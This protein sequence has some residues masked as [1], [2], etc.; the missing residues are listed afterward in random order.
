M[1]AVV[2]SDVPETQRENR[3]HTYRVLF[4]GFSVLRPEEPSV[5]PCTQ[6]IHDVDELPGALSGCCVGAGVFGPR[7]LVPEHVPVLVEDRLQ[8]AL[9]AVAEHKAPAGSLVAGDR[10]SGGELAKERDD[11]GPVEEVPEGV[12]DSHREPAA[13]VVG[14]TCCG[15][16][17]T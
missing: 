8:V 6:R 5:D 11:G 4:D 3:A 15:L 14:D 1:G 7:F 16:Q 17:A 13:G 10:G 2:G 9:Q 12:R